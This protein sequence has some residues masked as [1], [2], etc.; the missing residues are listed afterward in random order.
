MGARHGARRGARALK[1][2]QLG[3][4]QVPLPRLQL[5]RLHRLPQLCHA[6][7]YVLGAAV[8]RARRS[9]RIGE[10]CAPPAIRTASVGAPPLVDCD[11][12]RPMGS[13]TAKLFDSMAAL[14][15][16]AFATVAGDGMPRSISPLTD[17]V[18]QTGVRREL[19]GFFSRASETK[20]P[21]RVARLHLDH[22][23]QGKYGKANRRGL[24]QSAC[25]R[26]V[27]PILSAACH[28]RTDA[29][30]ARWKHGATRSTPAGSW[31]T[32]SSQPRCWQ[33]TVLPH[34]P[35]AC[36]TTAPTGWLWSSSAT[37]G[38]R[39]RISCCLVWRT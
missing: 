13:R 14:V 16:A 33:S 31:S 20:L 27:L 12:L 28:S 38:S 5:Q 7:F 22:R 8:L 25:R 34:R 37:S 30:R 39:A 32:A 1:V 2:G 24:G 19:E 3:H 17:E 18:L 6:R 4:E 29:Q 21:L 11:P 15:A 10:G 9:A 36:R 23:P 26:K 35:T